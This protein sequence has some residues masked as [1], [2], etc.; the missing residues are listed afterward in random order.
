MRNPESVE[1]EGG[2]S[3][4]AGMVVWLKAELRAS[5]VELTGGC[6]KLSVKLTTAVTLVGS[7]EDTLLCWRLNI[8]KSVSSCGTLPSPLSRCSTS[9]SGTPIP[10]DDSDAVKMT[11]LL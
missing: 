5:S 3:G 9:D 11:R 7:S 8:D 10:F 6:A 1:I 2:T 4:A